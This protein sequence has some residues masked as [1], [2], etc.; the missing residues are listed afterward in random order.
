MRAATD[1]HAIAGCS[2]V[3]PT[4]ARV[5]LGWAPAAR[6][7]RAQRIDV[8]I[9]SPRFDDGRFES[10]PILSPGDSRATWDDVGP[11]ALHYWRVLTLQGDVWVS[12]EVARFTPGACIGDAVGSPSP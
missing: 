8:T 9:F 6:D 12:S 10:R 5:E 1:L 3:D 7:G 11:G 2:P 4:H